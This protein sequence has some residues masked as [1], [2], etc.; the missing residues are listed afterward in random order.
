M[1]LGLGYLGC[2]FRQWMHGICNRESI[3]EEILWID[4][5]RLEQAMRHLTCGD[6]EIVLV[7][8]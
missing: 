2:V 1:D 6:Q 5:L 7:V 8:I 3:L 4:N